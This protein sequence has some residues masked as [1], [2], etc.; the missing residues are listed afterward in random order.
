MEELSSLQK[1]ELL[2]TRTAFFLREAILECKLRPG[3]KIVERQLA[4]HWNISRA[5]LR[6]VLRQLSSEGLVTL[7]PRRG[8]TVSEV[9]L[10]EAE[11][12]FSIRLM[13][14]SFCARVVAKGQAVA[15][16]AE[17]KRLIKVMKSSL[18]EG[19]LVEFSMAGRSFHDVLVDASGNNAMAELYE[20]TK[21]KFRRYQSLMATLPELPRRSVSEHQEIL[22]AI[23]ARDA[24]GAAAKVEAHLQHLIH[25]LV[26]SRSSILSE[27]VDSR[28][29]ATL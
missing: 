10:Q 12:L 27:V 8:A 29:S 19:D 15:T 1:P 20:R 21:A 2:T 7:L 9:S 13:I 14:E 24:D 23:V 4:E 25:Q 3:Q 18:A 16:I 17:M 28:P 11:E 5:T 6:E 26:A 22:D